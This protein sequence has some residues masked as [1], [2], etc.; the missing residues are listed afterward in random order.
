MKTTVFWVKVVLALAITSSCWIYVMRG[1]SGHP[2]YTAAESDIICEQNT[3]Q[4]DSLNSAIPSYKP[5]WIPRMDPWGNPYQH[6]QP[7]RPGTESSAIFVYSL[8][9]DG[10]SASG[11]HDPDDIN[12]QDDHHQAHYNRRLTATNLIWVALWLGTSIPVFGLL[13]AIHALLLPRP[14]YPPAR[15][16]PP[17]ENP[18]DFV[19]AN[20]LPFCSNRRREGN[21][22]TGDQ[23]RGAP[24][25]PA[26]D[27]DPA[28]LDHRGARGVQS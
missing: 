17:F 7:I 18:S 24:G 26:I 23:P 3:L 22:A 9:K 16:F 20:P 2:K 11:G 15:L 13:H 27:P 8:G 21:L 28:V 4:L 12:S 25:D 14:P 6:T 19:V 1:I 5:I 10:R